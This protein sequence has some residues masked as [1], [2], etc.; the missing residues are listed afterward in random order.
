MVGKLFI[1]LGQLGPFIELHF[2]YLWFVVSNRLCVY[3]KEALLLWLSAIFLS[4]LS[5]EI[6]GMSVV[7]YTKK[8]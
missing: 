3:V 8:H 7:P 5:C 6:V 1:D 2:T 4:V